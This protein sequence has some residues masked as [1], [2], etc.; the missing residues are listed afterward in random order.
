MPYPFQKT[1]ITIKVITNIYYKDGSTAKES[2]TLKP[3][4][5]WLILDII[6][7]NVY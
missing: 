7:K 3:I 2:T 6:N 1:C 4:L 5:I